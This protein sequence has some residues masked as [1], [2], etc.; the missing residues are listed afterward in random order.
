MTI[1]D[2]LT[3]IEV[4]TLWNRLR[5]RS[6]NARIEIEIAALGSRRQRRT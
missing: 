2:I 5:K 6:H 1:V 3:I 4:L